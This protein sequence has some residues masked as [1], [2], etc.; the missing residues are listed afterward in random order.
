MTHLIPISGTHG[1]GKSTLV[2]VLGARGWRIDTFQVSRAIQKQI[3]DVESL[4]EVLTN[5]YSVIAFQELILREKFRNDSKIKLQLDQHDIPFRVA[6]TERSFVDIAAYAALWLTKFNN[7][8]I[9][10]RWLKNYVKVCAEYQHM[11]YSANLYLNPIV[12]WE[13][14][15]NRANEEDREFI[16]TFMLDFLREN[17]IH[18]LTLTGDTP[19]SRADFAEKQLELFLLG[20]HNARQNQAVS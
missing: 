9:Y 4:S 15:P 13:D 11:L 8:A 12:H 3:F 2:K 17:S 1:C 5:P 19:D 18:T 16:N 20:A 7:H 10:M 14:D 6:L